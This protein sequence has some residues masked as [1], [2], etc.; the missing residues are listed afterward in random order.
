MTP[1]VQPLV[2]GQTATRSRWFRLGVRGLLIFTSIVALLLGWV[3][4][5]RRQSQYEH[6]VA[7]RLAGLG[8]NV[9]FG[10]PYDLIDFFGEDVPQGAWRNLASQLLGERIIGLQ[11]TPRS[12]E[13]LTPISGLKNLQ[14]L[15]IES[16]RVID[17]TPIGR[18]KNLNLL[19]I[20]SESL[21]DLTPI[22]GLKRLDTL[23]LV[24]MSV[25]DLTPLAG[26]KSLHRLYIECEL[27]SCDLSPIAALSSLRQLGFVG[28]SVSDAQVKFLQQA[29]PNCKFVPNV[30]PSVCPVP[31]E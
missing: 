7:K 31:I 2:T 21:V 8:C 4:K 6:Q 27:V 20:W 1:P 10:G 25:R 14:A 16:T 19:I 18:L 12:D 29:L 24:A 26:L 23:E 13:D 28:N 22:V 3:A 9:H 17:L 5:E 30:L 11:I 15:S